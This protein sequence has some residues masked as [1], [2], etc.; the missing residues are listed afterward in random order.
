MEKQDEKQKKGTDKNLCL[1][2]EM[3]GFIHFGEFILYRV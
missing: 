1:S 2:F 3:I